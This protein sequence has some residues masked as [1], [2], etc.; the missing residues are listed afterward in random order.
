MSS[1]GSAPADFRACV[2]LLLLVNL[3][4]KCG[5]ALAP[6]L[7]D[8]AP[9]LLL[10]LN[11]NDLHLALTAGTGLGLMPYCVVGG[12][13]RLLEDPLYYHL[14]WKYGT[15]VVDR[16]EVRRRSSSSVKPIHV[17]HERVWNAFFLVIFV[18]ERGD[19]KAHA[20]LN[21]NPPPREESE[22]KRASERLGPWRRGRDA[23]HARR[24]QEIRGLVP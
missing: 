19:K 8:S 3:A 1:G 4:S 9:T 11:A 6:R 22:T 21:P 13:R 20:P 15:K 17:L 18:G 23:R 12:L 24:R 7:V 14:G 10:A 16:L 5:D 2:A